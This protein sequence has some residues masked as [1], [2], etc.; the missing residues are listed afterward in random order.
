MSRKIKVSIIIFLF[1]PLFLSSSAIAAP[2]D[3]MRAPDSNENNDVFEKIRQMQNNVHTLSAT[4]EQEKNYSALKKA[5]HVNGRIILKKPNLLRWEADAPERSVIS[6]DGVTMTVYYPDIKEAKRYK[7]SEQ[8]I[9]KN[10]MRFF[11]S[12]MWGS[13]EDMEKQF[14]LAVSRDKGRISFELKPLSKIVRRYLSSVVISYDDRTGL[15]LSFEITTPKGDRTITT[16]S[17]IKV[18]PELEPDTFNLKLPHDVW[19]INN[20][21]PVDTD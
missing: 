2:A 13:F 10:T 9:A 8:F 17:D 15:P 20:I 14:A 3:S 5:I 4:I 19:I 21:E 16:L 6:V 11:S 7:L 18:N 1:L 12:I